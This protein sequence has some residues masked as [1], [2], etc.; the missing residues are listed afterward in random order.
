MRHS[1]NQIFFLCTKDTSRLTGDRQIAKAAESNVVGN[2]TKGFLIFSQCQ[3]YSV[4]F[5][6]KDFFYKSNI[7]IKFQVQSI[8]PKFMLKKSIASIFFTS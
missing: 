4:P 5:A 6:L 2:F 8:K 7:N 3:R 1:R